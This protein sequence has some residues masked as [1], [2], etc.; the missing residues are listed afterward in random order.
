M[1]QRS[2]SP[3]RIVSTEQGLNPIS[4]LRNE[5]QRLL[6]S[7]DTKNV[8][9]RTVVRIQVPL[10]PVN[11]IQ[12]LKAQESDVKVF[13]KGR[14]ENESIA[15]FG[16]AD[17]IISSE[18]SISQLRK[19]ERRFQNVGKARYFGGLRFDPRYKP[20]PEWSPFGRARFFLPR[21]ELISTN[22]SATLVCNIVLP[23]D[24]SKKSEI[25]YELSNLTIPSLDRS[26]ETNVPILREDF[27]EKASW[28]AILTDVI[29]KLEQADDLE[30]VVI[31]RKVTFLFD[32]NVD[33]FHL[34]EKLTSI[35]QQHFQ[36]FFQF[37]ED[38]VFMGAS[39]ERLYKRDRQYIESEAIAGTG[40]RSEDGGDDLFFADALIES[41][42]DQREHAF[43]RESILNSMECLCKTMQ[44][45]ASPS[46]LDLNMGRHLKSKFWG[47]LRDKTSDV[48]ILERIHPTSAVG[49]VP[50]E[51][52]MDT[53][54]EKEPFDRGW[55]A[56]P[57]GWI[58][59][60]SAEFSVAIRSAIVTKKSISLFS[61]AGIVKGSDP[62]S[63]WLEVEQKNSNFFK[64]LGLDQRTLKY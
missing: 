57:V 42:K 32:E 30:K 55:Y 58:G 44:I 38:H 1:V 18:A 10:N 17:E 7:K 34:F 20:S 14:N 51:K 35:A 52:A 41:E 23:S 46:I 11:P 54:R 26:G 47:V 27:P 40:L 62:E 19:A 5:V 36:F 13:W 3:E 49:G 60:N 9:D 61:G 63:E 48:D 29:R 56:G 21:F 39:P 12:W 53:I 50:T 22:D 15:A 4:Q 6:N 2:N 37:G 8:A 24:K 43:V 31:A 33:C 45:D 64:V 25:L 59:Q 16:I 28:D